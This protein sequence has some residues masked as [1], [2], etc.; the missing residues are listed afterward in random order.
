[1]AE[2]IDDIHTRIDEVETDVESKRQVLQN[3]VDDIYAEGT[4]RL[5]VYRLPGD[6]PLQVRIGG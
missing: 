5:R 3:Q 2:H 4:H 1:M 6:P